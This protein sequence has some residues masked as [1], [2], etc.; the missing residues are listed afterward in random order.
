M[1]PE[2]EFAEVVSLIR[3]AQTAAYRSVNAE[4]INN[5]WQ[6]GE[7]IS[8]RIAQSTWGERTVDELASYLE[9][10]H[11]DLKGYTLSALYRMRKFYE[12]YKDSEIV[13]PVAPK[14]QQIDNQDKGIVASLAPQSG[15]TDIRDT[16]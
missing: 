3:K 9:R 10:K 2:K 7:Y 6:L 4:L 13:A 15:S 14:I 5:Y 8:Q 12:T 11:P 1:Q 16:I